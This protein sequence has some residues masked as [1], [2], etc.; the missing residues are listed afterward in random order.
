MVLTMHAFIIP[1][2]ATSL[3]VDF[4]IKQLRE[5]SEL[6]FIHCWFERH[7]LHDWMADLYFAKGGTQKT[8]RFLTMALNL[9]DLAK[10]EQEVV[11]GNFPIT[12]RYV[13]DQTEEAEHAADLEFVARAREAIST[14]QAV[15]Y[16][17]W[18]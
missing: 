6:E 3:E 14:G 13:F 4:D 1:Q 2:A 8:A 18:W 15:I 11:A 12:S 5:M 16:R 17:S 9:A 7:K 10:L